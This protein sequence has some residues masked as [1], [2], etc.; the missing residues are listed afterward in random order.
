M[1][2]KKVYLKF[3]TNFKYVLGYRIKKN[4]ND[5]LLKS[6]EALHSKVYEQNC[7]HKNFITIKPNIIR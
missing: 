1:K 5:K 4:I 2:S 3:K 7:G 6:N